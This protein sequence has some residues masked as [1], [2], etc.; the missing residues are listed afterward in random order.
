M[1]GGFPG[2]SVVKNPSANAGDMVLDRG[3]SWAIYSTWGRKRV[4][5]D[6]WTKQHNSAFVVVQLLSCV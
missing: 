5:D 3:V 6:L 4:E 1:G 2:G